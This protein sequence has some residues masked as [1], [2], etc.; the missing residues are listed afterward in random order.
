MYFLTGKTVF[1]M[2]ISGHTARTVYGD[3]IVRDEDPK[4]CWRE[5]TMRRGMQQ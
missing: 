4:N 3:S 2:L 1:F 5:T